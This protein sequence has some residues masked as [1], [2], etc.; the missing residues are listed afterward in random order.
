MQ[1]RILA[2]A[3]AFAFSLTSAPALASDGHAEHHSHAEHAIAA[4][5]A[6]PDRPE[7]ARNLDESR[8]PAETLT[9]LGLEPGM[10]VA[11]ILPGNGYWSEIIGHAVQ[12][13][14]S[15]TALRAVNF[16][17][18]ERNYQIWKGVQERAPGVAVSFYQF[19]HFSY[20]PNSF[21]FAITNLNFHDLYWVSDRFDISM[22]D[23]D[24]FTNALYVAMRPG[25]I[26]GVI[27]H[28]GPEGDT[29][30]IVEA[31]HR[32]A[33]SV[34]IADMQRAGFELVGQS[35]LLANPDDDQSQ[36][37]FAAGIRGQTDRFL[38]KFRKPL[39]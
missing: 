22:T 28:T 21:D 25:G 10:D 18:S 33:P 37:V 13:E 8:K 35:D 15:V 36:S 11:D 17:T 3:S 31:T 5:V 39:E 30:A 1:T 16:S 23:P 29:R 6:A 9:F 2:L 24:E 19:E 26:V 14:G 7:A 4:A 20:A 38:L 32:I 12:P 34:V 27:D